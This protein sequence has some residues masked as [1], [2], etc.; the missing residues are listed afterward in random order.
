MVLV[1]EI[2]ALSGFNS[3]LSY[4]LATRWTADLRTLPCR[5]HCSCTDIADS[6]KLCN[7]F[8]DILPSLHLLYLRKPI[9][10]SSSTGMY[11]WSTL[12]TTA[13]SLIHNISGS[14]IPSRLQF[15]LTGWPWDTFNLIGDPVNFIP[16]KKILLRPT[17]RRRGV[18][19]QQITLGWWSGITYPTSTHCRGVC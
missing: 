7:S 17:P 19:V 18:G 1:H 10:C 2:S 6:R 15:S 8:H 9:Q 3:A 11:T 14:S 12:C 5:R 16:K 4:A 13:P